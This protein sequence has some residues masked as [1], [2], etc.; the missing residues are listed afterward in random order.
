MKIETRVKTEEVDS[1]S[2]YRTQKVRFTSEKSITTPTKSIPLDRIK[3]SDGLNR[4]SRQLNEIFKRLTAKQIKEAN[5]DNNKFHQLEI[6]FNSQKNKVIEGTTTFCFIDF[7]EPRMPTDEE[8]EFMTDLAYCNSDITTIPTINHFNRPKQTE[9]TFED[10]KKFLEKAI[11][12]IEQLNHKP[13]M[14]IIPKF[15]PKR[16]GELLEFYQNKGINAFSIDLAGSNPI[17]SYLRIFKVLKSLKKRK[18]LETSYI[19]GYNVGKRVNKTENIIPAKDILG[20]GI[21]LDSLGEK[22]APFKPN[23]AFLEKGPSNKFTLFN[24]KGYGYWKDISPEKVPEVFPKDS[25]LPLERFRNCKK[26]YE[27]QRVFN[28]EQ[29]ALEAHNLRK[30]IREESDEA[31]GY[32]KKKKNVEG[33]DIRLLETAQKKIK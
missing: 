19:H 24:K 2:L 12:S 9:I 4:N 28:A 1:N 18:I 17:S 13:I 14:G 11:E 16:T 20:F 21:G 33:S 5:E 26:P 7:N 23:R 8:I 29:L 32:V 27:L 30:L 10:Y 31:L 15:A 6:Q 25:E 22:R 3:S